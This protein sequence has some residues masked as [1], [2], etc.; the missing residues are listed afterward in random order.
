M[1]KLFSLLMALCLMLSAM[2]VV[3]ADAWIPAE[4]EINKA[5]CALPEKEGDC[6]A[7]NAFLTR[8]VE[9][10]AT[11]LSEYFSTEADYYNSL[12]KHFELNPQLY[13]QAVRSYTDAEGAVY[14][15]IDAT[16][17][18]TA[19]AEL[20]NTKFPI[21][22]CP[23]YADGKIRVSAANYGAE[24]K[25]FAS[26]TYCDIMGTSLYW[27]SFEVYATDG[28]PEDYLDI[29]NSALDKDS[30][31][32]LAEGSGLFYFYGDTTQDSFTAD[33]FTFM[34]KNIYETHNEFPYSTDNRPA[35][36]DVLPDDES[37]LVEV[38]TSD[39]EVS[40]DAVKIEDPAADLITGNY[41]TVP[42]TEPD[43]TKAEQR[44]LLSP[45][46]WI[47]LGVISVAVVSFVII[48]LVFKKKK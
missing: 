16:C 43:E 4:D 48:L 15:E 38:S 23:G 27:V 13:P 11:E 10:G 32:L 25:V 45:T 9:T 39:S 40:D 12:L 37:P 22:N 14:M 42:E 34:E 44:F 17:F 1:K 47:A 3:F 2:P 28:D 19:M 41:E 29:P 46:A 30:I 5:L 24:K 36:P 20:Y 21:E 6:A 26:A 35:P 31:T 7:L 18:E 33:D 8:Y